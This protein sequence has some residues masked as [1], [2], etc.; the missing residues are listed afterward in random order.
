MKGRSPLTATPVNAALMHDAVSGR[1]RLYQ[2][3][4]A[5]IATATLGEVA[6]CLRRVEHHVEALGHHA[7]G[8]VSY[9]ASPA[10]DAA[11]VVRADPRPA[12]PLLWFGIYAEPEPFD[13]PEAVVE[14]AVDPAVWTPTMS[15]DA[16]AAAFDRIK[17]AIWAG[18]TYQVNLTY[19]LRR[20]FDAASAWS[21]FLAMSAA[22]RSDYGAFIRTP[23]WAVCSASPELFFSLTGTR[24]VSRPMKGT[25]PRLPTAEADQ[26]QAEALRTSEKNAAEN[27]MIVDMV[28]NDLGRIAEVGSVRVPERLTVERYPTVWQLTSRVTAETTASVSGIFEALF[29][30]ASIT[31]APKARAMSVIAAVETTPRGLY[32]G[33]IGWLAPGRRAQFNVAIRTLVADVRT[34]GAEYGIGGGI[35]WDSVCAAEAAECRDK[36]AILHA[37]WPAFC[38]LESLLW[39]PAEGYVLLE[40]HLRRLRASADYFGYRIDE[41]HGRRQLDAL[42]ARLPETPHKIR[43]RVDR[44]GVVRLEAEA[45]PVLA[46]SPP[47]ARVALAPTPVDRNDVFLYHKTTRRAVYDA[48][49]AAV[50]GVDDV[51]LWNEAGEVTE[52]TRANVV[53]DL[54]G[55]RCTP[56]VSCGL[57]AGTWRERMLARGEVV[58]RVIPVAA[59]RRGSRLWLVN[60]V[61][62]ERPAVWS[63]EGGE[64]AFGGVLGG[65]AT[66]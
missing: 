49:L 42:A 24:L 44:A 56:P 48:A 36:A 22:Q 57:L 55:V 63:G 5:I 3:P 66:L 7:A 50:P 33:S 23:D 35:V 16:Y 53:V 39:T 9:D 45:L 59:L 10:F 28:R 62:G 34:G 43:M 46:A 40:E 54:D 19:R 12:I 20:P 6:A 8:F 15:D 32:T 31:G 65:D 1:W 2:N 58:E 25:A 51:V 13:W 47:P 17:R 52:T 21:V 18:D 61:R 60:S 30:P 11:L 27:L 14:G 41:A 37:G 26:R 4:V 29:P 38:L 64:D